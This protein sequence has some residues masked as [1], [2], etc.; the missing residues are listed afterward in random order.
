MRP[1]HPGSFS[2]LIGEQ[3]GRLKFNTLFPCKHGPVLRLESRCWAGRRAP[4]LALGGG[5]P[6]ANGKKLAT[7]D[8]SLLLSWR[9]PA[10][11]QAEGRLPSFS[12]ILQRQG[13]PLKLYPWITFIKFTASQLKLSSAAYAMFLFLGFWEGRE[14]KMTKCTDCGQT[15]LSLNPCSILTSFETLDQLISL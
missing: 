11:D 4:F 13:S 8:L 14:N 1:R 9:G 6:M 7:E 2:S 10:Y 15:D 5:C 12:H 3:V